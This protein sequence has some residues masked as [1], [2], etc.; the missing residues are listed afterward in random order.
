MT[1]GF[2]EEGVSV[3]LVFLAVLPALVLVVW[4]YKKDKVEREPIGLLLKIFLF[5]VISVVPAVALELLFEVVLEEFIPDES[6]LAYV[7]IDNFLG[8]AL[9]E[10]FCKLK[11]AKL[12]A[13]KHPAFNYKFDAIVYCVTAALGFAAIENVFYVLEGGVATA[14]MRA[15]LS[16]PC[17]AVAGIIMGYFFGVA[18]EAESYGDRRRRRRYLRLGVLMPTLEHGIYDSALS[19]DYDWI[20]I[21]LIVFVVIVDIWAIC[22]VKKQSAADREIV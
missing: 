14:A 13:W 22:F 17:H 4:I 3:M 11:A 1:C 12:A 5:G 7:I 6:A 15:L 18:K 8:V 21:V 19:L 16:I 10:E 9:I 20:F 2:G